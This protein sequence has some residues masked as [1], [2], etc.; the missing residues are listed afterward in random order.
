MPITTYQRRARKTWRERRRAAGLSWYC[1]VSNHA[2]C[3][4]QVGRLAEIGVPRTS[5]TCPC[6][7]D[8]EFQQELEDKLW[9]D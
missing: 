8:P 1:V 5:C 6:H 4:G 3:S 9:G 7:D 2:I